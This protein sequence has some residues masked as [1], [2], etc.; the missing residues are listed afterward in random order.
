VAVFNPVF[1]TL[2]ADHGL[3]IAANARL[4][5]MLYLTTADAA[6]GCWNDK[7]RWLLWRP[8]TAI[9]EAGTDGNRATAA[10]TA[11]PGS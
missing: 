11:W 9:H 3:G 8:T 7:A 5:G 1:R 4:M 2:A 10:D 6:I